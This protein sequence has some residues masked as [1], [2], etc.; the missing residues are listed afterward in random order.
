MH[1]GRRSARFCRARANTGR[2]LA[3]LCL[4]PVTHLNDTPDL[5]RHGWRQRRPWQEAVH[6][7]RWSGGLGGAG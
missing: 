3:W 2:R 7:D 4:G 1:D 6:T 5:E